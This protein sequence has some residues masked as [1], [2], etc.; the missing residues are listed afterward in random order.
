MVHRHFMQRSSLSIRGLEPMRP[1][2]ESSWGTPDILSQRVPALVEKVL[3][4]GHARKG[5]TLQDAAMMVGILQ[6]LVFDSETTLLEKVYRS[7]DKR[8]TW[9]L[10]RVG[11]HQILESYIVHWIMGQDEEGVR[12]LEEDPMLLETQFPHWKQVSGFVL[13]QIKNFE[14]RR[15]QSLPAV[16]D[17]GRALTG[18]FT[19]DEA[20]EIVGSITNSFGLY[21]ETECRVMKDALVKMDKSGTGR[22]RLSEF[23]AAALD[24]EW[25]FGESEAYLRQLGALDE[26]SRWHGKQVIIPNYLQAASNCIV[27]TDYYLVCCANECEGLMDEIELAIPKPVAEVEEVLAAVRNLT[28]NE[29]DEPVVVSRVL[30]DSLGQIA[31]KHGG[32]VP[33]HG[34]LFAQWLHYLFPRECP[35]PHKA[36]NAASLLPHQ[37]GDGYVATKDE[38]TAHASRKNATVAGDREGDHWMSQWSHE[39]ELAADYSSHIAAPWEARHGFTVI[40]LFMLA[41]GAALWSYVF[42]GG[43]GLLRDL[44][45]GSGSHLPTHSMSGGKWKMKV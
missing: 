18:R 14:R 29:D 41:A 39:E 24:D 7:G 3:Q 22:V 31:R 2:N 1:A 32:K 19:F 35:F 36:G 8:T 42:G 13:G 34:R 37:Y 27:G 45:R 44:M 30:E 25:R 12:A 23:Y 40:T 26:T 11:L 10:S 9:L 15:Q 21:W 20:H 33:I 28:S 5:F 38:L 4:G 6:Q 17:S 16:K 43:A